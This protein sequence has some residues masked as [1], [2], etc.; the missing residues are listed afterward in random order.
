MQI[1]VEYHRRSDPVIFVM[2]KKFLPKFHL[3]P[4]YCFFLL[5]RD[6]RQ[7]TKAMPD[8]GYRGNMEIFQYGI[9][10]TGKFIRVGRETIHL[11]DNYYRGQKH[12]I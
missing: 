6:P 10:H 1:D 5:G 9:Y 11:T 7:L 4:H 3:H 8:S 2:V 12:I